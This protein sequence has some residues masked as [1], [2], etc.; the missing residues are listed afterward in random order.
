VTVWTGAKSAE[1]V[2]SVRICP[3][4]LGDY[5]LSQKL[6]VDIDVDTFAGKN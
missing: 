2:F 1:D 3:H 5:I 6:L 4:D